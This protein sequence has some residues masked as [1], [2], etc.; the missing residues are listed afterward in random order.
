MSQFVKN[1]RLE[2]IMS[3]KYSCIVC[4]ESSL[5]DGNI[6]RRIIHWKLAMTD[7][8]SGMIPVNFF[9]AMHHVDSRNSLVKLDRS[10]RGE[11][12]NWAFPFMSIGTQ[13][14]YFKYKILTV[15]NNNWSIDQSNI[16]NI[17]FYFNYRN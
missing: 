16:L 15:I 13:I 14:L 12:E 10:A 9:Q 3:R 5:A 4:R 11:H 2:S 17:V 1:T 8:T 6:V 7:A